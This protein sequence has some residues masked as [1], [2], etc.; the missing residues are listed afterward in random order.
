MWQTKILKDLCFIFADGDWIEKKDQS[1][2][3]IRLVQTGN[4][5]MG[6]FAERQDKAR[7]ISEDTFNRLNCTE[8]KRGDIL[9]SRLPE[10]VGRATIIPE[11][12]D[13]AITAVDCTIIRL[14]E[15]ILPTYLNYYMQSPNYL[16]SIQSKV[17]GATRQR[18][19]RKNLGEIPII[20]PPLAEQERIVAKL[21]AAFAEIEAAIEEIVK[22]RKS[23]TRLH[24]ATLINELNDDSYDWQFKELGTIADNLDS[25]RVPIT[26]SKRIQGSVPYYGASGIVDYVEGYLFDEDLLL[27]SE[28]GAN[29]LMRTYPIAFSVSGK[30]WVNN[31]AH[32]LRFSDKEIQRWV[33]RYL[34]TI[35]LS[36]YISGM[37]QP[38]L[39]QKKLNSIPIP[40]PSKPKF[41]KL[42]EI[43]EVLRVKSD[44]LNEIYSEK[45][46]QLLKLKSAFLTQELQPPQNE[47]A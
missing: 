3:G 41:L 43:I 42:L 44:D 6:Y 7:Y 25:A 8:I 16:S 2:A 5:K 21:D 35:D 18:I 9:V 40:L 37:A 13:K 20:F 30:T 17:T 46:A 10:P 33:E 1:D 4:I 29:L 19:S 38:K 36:K 32:V 26:K 23:V 14:N 11:L 22:A 12:K 34:N 39:N 28:D 45:E 27:I 47:A 31:H 15:E 24:N